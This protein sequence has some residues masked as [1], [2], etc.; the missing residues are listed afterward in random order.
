[1]CFP[2]VDKFLVATQGISRFGNPEERCVRIG[3]PKRVP[4]IFELDLESGLSS[5]GVRKD[6]QFGESDWRRRVLPG[7]RGRGSCLGR[8]WRLQPRSAVQCEDP[9]TDAATQDKRPTNHNKDTAGYSAGCV[10]FDTAGSARA[11]AD[12]QARAIANN[13]HLINHAGPVS[14][15]RSHNVGSRRFNATYTQAAIQT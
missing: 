9:P 2:Q 15:K 13:P 5:D 6:L 3:E 4:A 10:N 12:T 7:R 1:M 8:S 11:T 14:R